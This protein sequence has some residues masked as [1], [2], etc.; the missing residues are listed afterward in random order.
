MYYYLRNSCMFNIEQLCNRFSLQ[1]LLTGV[2]QVFIA[3]TWVL[4]GLKPVFVSFSYSDKVL[5]KLNESFKLVSVLEWWNDFFGTL[6]LLLAY[7]LLPECSVL[8]FFFTILLF[9][10]PFSPLCNI[11]PVPPAFWILPVPVSVSL[12]YLALPGSGPNIRYPPVRAL[13]TPEQQLALKGE[14]GE[15]FLPVCPCIC[16]NKHI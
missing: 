13:P 14:E 4:K 15:C 2:T 11:F 10:P 3:L 7:V 9:Q 5:Q 6:G 16:P 12:S 1:S 8:S